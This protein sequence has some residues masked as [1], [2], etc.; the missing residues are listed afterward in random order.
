M[1]KV[2]SSYGQIIFPNLD[3]NGKSVLLVGGG[4]TTLEYDRW[5]DINTDYKVVTTECYLNK[6]MRNIIADF[7][8]ISTRIN[9]LCDEFKDW[10]NANK[11]IRF[12]IEPKHLWKN[13]PGLEILNGREDLCTIDMKMDWK[14]GIVARLVFAFTLMGFSDVYVVGFDGYSK[15]GSGQHAYRKELSKLDP[16]ARYNTYEQYR[17]NFERF[18]TDYNQLLINIS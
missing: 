11:D 18:V 15:D 17:I 14:I 16:N 10:H 3:T 8:V 13:P 5:I 7:Y 9:M 1:S 6:N 2:N 12:I 4:P